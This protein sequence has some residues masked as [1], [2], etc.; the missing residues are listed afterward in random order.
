[1]AAVDI[2]EEG[3]VD[4]GAELLQLGQGSDDLRRHGEDVVLLRAQPGRDGLDNDS[5]TRSV[6][7]PLVYGRY[8][9]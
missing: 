5:Q 9:V 8:S 2:T 1:M 4:V 6:P 3:R 7:L